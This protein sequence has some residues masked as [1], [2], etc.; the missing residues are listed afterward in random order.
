MAFWLCL[1]MSACTL[2]FFSLTFTQIVGFGTDLNKMSSQPKV[3][4]LSRHPVM[5]RRTV[6]FVVMDGV[7][8]GPG[9]QYDAVASARK[10]TLDKL[11]ARKDGFRAVRAHGTAVGLPS[12]ADMG[13]SEVGHN[14]IGCGRV[15]LQGAS[16]VDAALASGA[17]FQSSGFRYLQEAFSCPGKTLHFIGLLS[18][19][20]VHSRD[21]QLYPIIKYSAANGAKR[22]RV[23][24]LT[25]GRDVP[26]GSSYQFIAE[27]EA[28][29]AEVNTKNGCDAKI[30]SGGGRMIVT[31]DRYEADWKVV[32][33]GWK[34]HVLGEARPFP[35]AKIALETLKKED[36]KVSDQ[37][38][39]PFTVVDPSGKPVGT[40]EDG[41]AV[42]CINFRGDRA[43]EISRAFE[44]GDS[45]KY[46]DRKR[47]PKVHYAGMMQYDG[48]LGVP[49]HS[50]VAPPQISRTSGEYLAKSGVR[51][52][53]VSETQKYGHVTYFWNG[54]RSGK[55]DNALE[56]F[57]EIPSDRVVFNTA[58]KMKAAEITE[59]AVEAIRSRKY[60]FIRLNYPNGDMV[61]HTG[62]LKASI[63]AIEAVDAGLA[64][65]VEAI[66]SVGGVFLITA[67]HGNADDMVQR[68]KGKVIKDANGNPVPLTSHTLNPVP[69]MIG[70]SGLKKG[71]AFRKDLPKAGLANLTATFINLLGYEA[72]SDYEPSL[73]HIPRQAHL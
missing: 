46:F 33:R 4:K 25:D 36:P 8:I 72:P 15:I 20:G 66:D 12:D 24:V 69:V 59:K 6:L 65:L 68:K 3:T 49:K 29:L 37:F 35:S 62:D 34:A 21:N 16:L 73:L 2:Q 41:D 57:V 51:T 67:D 30:A 54:N 38:Y 19:G 27:L 40:V 42:L 71:V 44:E 58:P 61:G 23:H 22:I 53:A 31:M 10:P 26:D 17:L 18:N 55:F 11:M 39:P 13:N 7:G 45:F 60:D 70:G 56:T 52:F 48:D 47:V 14:A 9:D 1:K 5:P 64:K 28:V 63:V 50:V 43:I 32:E